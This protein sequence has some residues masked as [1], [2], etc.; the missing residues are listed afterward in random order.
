[1]NNDFKALWDLEPEEIAELENV[2]WQQ[3]FKNGFTPLLK[4]IHHSLIDPNAQIETAW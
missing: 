1:M 4:Q 3:I 2:D